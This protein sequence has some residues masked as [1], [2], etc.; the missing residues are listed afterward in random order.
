MRKWLL[1]HPIDSLVLCARAQSLSRGGNDFPHPRPHL[2]Q[3]A[4]ESFL[5][6]AFLCSSEEESIASIAPLVVVECG[7]QVCQC[8]CLLWCCSPAGPGCER[9]KVGEVILFVGL[10]SLRGGKD[11]LSSLE[12]QLSLITTKTP[13]CCQHDFSTWQGP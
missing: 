2:C 5:S 10:T 4:F 1:K 11:T 3:H 6:E 12:A 9:D 13:V 8:P 7:L